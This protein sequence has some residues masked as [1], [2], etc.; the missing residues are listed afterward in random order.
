MVYLGAF[1]LILFAVVLLK[2]RDYFNDTDQHSCSAAP[3]NLKTERKKTDQQAK[4]APAPS[5]LPPP[6]VAIGN[7][8]TPRGNLQRTGY[9][10][11]PDLKIN[12]GILWKFETDSGRLQEPIVSGNRI[13]AGTSGGTDKSGQMIALELTGGAVIWSREISGGV[14]TPAVL[15]DKHLIFAAFNRSL[16]ALDSETGKDTWIKDFGSRIFCPVYRNGELLIACQTGVSACNPDDGKTLWQ[17]NFSTIISDPVIWGNKLFVVTNQDIVYAINLDQKKIDQTIDCQQNCMGQL[18]V[19]GDE[20]I[21]QTFG[22]LLRVDLHKWSFKKPIRSPGGESIKSDI[23]FTP[24]LSPGKIAWGKEQITIT[25]VA[26]H[27]AM[28][29]YYSQSHPSICGNTMY[30]ADSDGFKAIDLNTGEEATIIHN[31]DFAN[32][33]GATILPAPVLHD[34]KA[35]VCNHRGT[36]FLVG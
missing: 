29:S 36:I 5:P 14:N 15:A 19:L 21:I 2:A 18:A 30:V 24:A 12:L 1:F 31:K 33:A 7:A 32:Y 17:I 23:E 11:G 8:S 6:D 13:F 25:S 34:G 9:Y 10:A 28:F 4:P 16:V 27:K 26:T 35:L 22:Y 3:A 20:L